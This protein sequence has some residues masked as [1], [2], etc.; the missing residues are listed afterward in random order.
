MKIRKTSLS[1]MD[2]PA[3]GSNVEQET[4]IDTSSPV[5]DS[6]MNPVCAASSVICI[7]L[8]GIKDDANVIPVLH[9]VAKVNFDE[10]LNSKMDDFSV[11]KNKRIDAHNHMTTED[12]LS[13][14]AYM[15]QDNI[16]GN[17]A[18]SEPKSFLKRQKS[19]I[20]LVDTN[21]TGTLHCKI[22]LIFAVCCIIGCCL[23]PTIFY[24]ISQTRNRVAITDPEYSHINNTSAKVSH[25]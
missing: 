4:T 6:S 13:H 5:N 24:Y 9:S 7:T 2:G 14:G 8:T 22:L 16:T 20:S 3:V 10:S 12:N 18:T 1:S 19:N 25:A 11:V 21:G 23:M 15:L 17:N